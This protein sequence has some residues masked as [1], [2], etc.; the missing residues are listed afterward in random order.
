[1][2]KSFINKP[3]NIEHNR[4]RVIGTI[5]SAGFSEFG[6]DSPL[7]EEQVK[8]KTEPFNI[9]L[10]GI[11]W[12]VV[13]SP[14]ANLVENSSD[15]SSESYM[16]ISASWELGFSDYD[17]IITDEEE[18][19]IEN[20]EI[21]ANEERILELKEYLKALGGDGRLEDGKNVYR[22]VINDVLPLGIGLT[23]CP[24]ADVKGVATNKTE[25]KPL[26]EE[27][28]N[29]E[30]KTD[31]EAEATPENV[32]LEKNVS[33]A[34]KNNVM[35]ERRSSLFMKI[36]SIKDITDESLQTLSASAISDFIEEEI[37]RASEDY[38]AKKTEV[39]NTLKESHDKH[40][41]LV[42]EHEGVKVELEK[43]KSSLETLEKEKVERESEEK[44]NQ[45]MALMD[46]KYDLTDEDR[47]VVASDIKDFDEEQFDSYTQK[48]EV[49]L[50]GKL[51]TNKEEAETTEAKASNTENVEEVLDEAK[52][53][54]ENIPNSTEPSEENTYDKYKHAFSVDQFDIDL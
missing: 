24:A 39:E 22:R 26:T 38:E 28:A 19:N 5:L 3:I 43:V 17:I 30:E 18:K 16:R 14:L 35:K 27:S 45:R 53:K 41:A 2:Y 1:M 44:F 51:K 49:L 52:E 11:L 15:P 46:E 32:I 23:E 25:E 40:E 10:G 13:N 7:T 37:R 20:G 54:E 33:Q 21:V 4:E 8:D 47:S 48:M 12:K 6:T 50:K 31:S 34:E 29:S 36:T 9:T 42:S